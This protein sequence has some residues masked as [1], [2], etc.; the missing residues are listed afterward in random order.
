M[1]QKSDRFETLRRLRAR[2]G[3]HTARR[4]RLPRAVRR[5]DPRNLIWVMPAEE[6]VPEEIVVVV[7]GGDPPHPES[8]LAVPLGARVIA[9][10]GGLDHA[11][12]LR[13]E[14]SVAIGD[15]GSASP[16]AIP[17]AEGGGA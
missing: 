6:G 13:L 12:A 2:D 9:A 15:F 1:L 17:R 7:A 16:E 3:G 5:A 11:L 14:G 4:A 8:V 10:D